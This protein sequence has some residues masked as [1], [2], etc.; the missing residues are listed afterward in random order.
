MAKTKKKNPVKT[1]KKKTTKPEQPKP[2]VTVP[3]PTAGKTVSDF[4]QELD[5]QI[6]DNPE[7]AHGGARAGAGRKTKPKEP[8]PPEVGTVPLEAIRSALTELLKAPFDIWAA[9]AG[10]PQLALTQ[11][12][13]E[14]L[15]GPVQTLLDHY[16]PN[17]RPIDW[18]WVMFAIT[19]I[20]IMRPRMVLLQRMNA[21]EHGGREQQNTPPPRTAAA[22]AP[23]AGPGQQGTSPDGYKPQKL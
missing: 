4:E 2:V 1:K 10:V 13:A 8:P 14:T 9:K 3:M 17:M 20:G 6:A 11:D 7:P 22:V 15:T 18:A 19:A 16:I 12:E 23:V 21:Q 5:K